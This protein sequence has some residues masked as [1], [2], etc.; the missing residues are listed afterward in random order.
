M[1]GRRD[2]I[3]VV[4]G[5]TAAWPL[6]ARAQQ[7]K[8]DRVGVLLLDDAN[9]AISAFF[10][11][12]LR[13]EMSKAGYVEQQNV[14][15]DLVSTAGKIDQL[16]KL[17]GALVAL[18]VDLIVA[19]LT[20]CAHAAK[21]ATREIPI[22]AYAGDPVGT[23][24]VASLP[25]PGGNITGVSAMTS[26][27]HGKCVE[28]FKDMLPSTHRIGALINAADISSK[29]I[30][31]QIQNVGKMTGI[32]ITPTVFVRSPG[33]IDAAFAS[34]KKA[35]ADAVVLQGSIPA[36]IAAELALTHQLP[37]ATAFRPFAEA[38]GLMSYSV[39]FA[40]AFRMTAIS[41]VKVLHGAKPADLP[42]EQPTKFDLVINMKTAKALGL[43]VPPTLLSRADDVIE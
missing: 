16:P 43:T 20:P 11:G 1:I 19:L 37:A 30:L 31:D 34:I 14:L 26:E 24:L 22:V 36:K 2:F 10:L 7:K 6:A 23:G 28:L 15:F 32:E 3:I 21:Q 5:A 38:G 39:S 33:E 42:V 41:A 27:L 9:A 12:V 4:G 8:I 25:R 13:D 29:P 35:G 18:K 40:E 17:A